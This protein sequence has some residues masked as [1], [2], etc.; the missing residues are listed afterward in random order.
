MHYLTTS[1]GQ[2]SYIDDFNNDLVRHSNGEYLPKNVNSTL[3]AEP[4]TLSLAIDAATWEFGGPLL[5][6]VFKATGSATNIIFKTLRNAEWFEKGTEIVARAGG[7]AIAE[8]VEKPG[9]LKSISNILFKGAEND[10]AWKTLSTTDKWF[11]EIGQKALPESI[12]KTVANFGTDVG[13]VVSKGR[14]LVQTQRLKAFAPSFKGMADMSSGYLT[15]GMTPLGRWFIP[16]AIGTTI[17]SLGS[18]LSR[19]QSNNQNTNKP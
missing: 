11:Y 5:K 13:S 2:I 3:L 10:K 8:T 15:S 14:Y 19:T 16:R 4:S 18:Y 9:V 7:T 12:W 1:D 6:G 17:S